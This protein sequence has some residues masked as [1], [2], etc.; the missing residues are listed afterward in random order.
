VVA[1]AGASTLWG[2]EQS[3]HR[4]WTGVKR[5]LLPQ[6]GNWAGANPYGEC[7]GMSCYKT[8]AAWSSS[9]KEMR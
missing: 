3:Q 9:C 1:R 7:V 5:V 8:S 6:M 2:P 4:Q